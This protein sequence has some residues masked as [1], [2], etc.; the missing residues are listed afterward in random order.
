MR[1]YTIDNSLNSFKMLLIN[2][3]YERGESMNI[4]LAIKA[5]AK[6][7]GMSQADLHRA[8]GISEG[9]ISMLFNAKID[10]PQLSKMWTLSKALGV[11]VDEMIARSLEGDE[12]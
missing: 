11:T 10:D 9:Y 2:F 1:T 7:K 6:E 4:G 5:I 3:T 12:S 8:T